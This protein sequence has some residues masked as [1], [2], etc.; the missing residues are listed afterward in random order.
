MFDCE[1]D[2]NNDDDGMCH[3]T[4]G[5]IESLRDHV[6]SMFSGFVAHLTDNK[7]M[8]SFIAEHQ[9]KFLSVQETENIIAD[10]C[11]LKSDSGAYAIGANSFEEYKEKMMRLFH[12]LSTRI[13]SNVMHEGVNLGLLDAEFNIETGEFDFELTEKGKK[14]QIERAGAADSANTDN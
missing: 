1:D 11:D 4:M 2:E 13:M 5:S 14:L 9:K 3:H 6:L 10:L 8:P 12:A 7:D